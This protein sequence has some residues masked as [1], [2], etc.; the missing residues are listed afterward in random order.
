MKIT[1]HKIIPIALLLLAGCGG[2]GG[3]SEKDGAAGG[4]GVAG[5][6]GSAGG[7]SAGGTAGGGGTAASG[8]M[9]MVLANGCAALT[10]PVAAPG[11]NIG[12]DT[13][14]TYAKPFFAQWCTRCHS[15][16]LVGDTARN[17]A[18]AGYNWDQ[19][20][21][22][23]MYGSMIRTEVGANDEM[24]PTM[25]FPTCEDRLRISKWLDAGQP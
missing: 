3:S 15:S 20:A 7:G 23:K 1:M 19:Q 21:A 22:V 11:D 9:T 8:D 24:P 2:S 17:G 13:W 4:G 14:A 16:T 10:S 6:G 18:P 12:G 5:G 25:P